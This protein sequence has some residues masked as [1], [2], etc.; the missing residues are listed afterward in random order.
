MRYEILDAVGNEFVLPIDMDLSNCLV[1]VNGRLMSKIR[2][3][4]LRESKEPIL[5]DGKLVA[6]RQV[7]HL[8]KFADDVD[9]VVIS[10]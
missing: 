10:L 5:E 8:N 6:G 9:I 2:Y 3:T 1:F 7:L 4:L